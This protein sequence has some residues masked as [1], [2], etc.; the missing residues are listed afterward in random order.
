MN[1]KMI[2]SYING[3]LGNQMFQYAIGRKLSI[4]GDVPLKLDI[5]RFDKDK[6]RRYL[7]GNY[8]IDAEIAP[9]KEIKKYKRVDLKGYNRLESLFSKYNIR[10][11]NKIYYEKNDYEFDQK[12]LNFDDIYIKGY[13]QSYKYFQDIREILIRDLSLKDFI[14]IENKSILNTILKS[15]SVSVHIR[16]GDLNYKSLISIDYYYK[17]M[18]YVNKKINNPYFFIFSDDI[19]WAKQNLIF[20]YNKFFVNINNDHKTPYFDL[21]L[22]RNCK[23]NII[24]NSTFSWWGAW[25]NENMGKIVVVPKKWIK[26]IK[27]DD[28]IPEAWIKIYL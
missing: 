13:W 7:L 2:I 25:L 6:K 15:N 17:A 23:H 18:D 27:T 24:A 14:E 22:M 4:I 10:L 16:R 20:N 19:E 8:N 26:D 11:F 12:V 1:K 3:G 9:K 28:L 5:S 21:E